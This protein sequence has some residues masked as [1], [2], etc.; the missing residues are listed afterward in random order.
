MRGAD[1]LLYD[2]GFPSDYGSVIFERVH[3]NGK[4]LGGTALAAHVRMVIADPEGEP[5]DFVVDIP[6]MREA[7]R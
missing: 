2:G 6:M 1:S 4:M 7:D 5:N 3:H